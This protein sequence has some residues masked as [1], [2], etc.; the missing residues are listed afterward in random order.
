MLGAL[1][2]ASIEQL[3]DDIPVALRATALDLPRSRAGAGTGAPPERLGGAQPDG[4]GHLPGGRRLPP[5]VPAA[6]DQILLRGECYT[7]YTPYQPE[8]SQGTLQ[9]IYEYQSLHGRADR[10]GRRV[11]LALRRGC[12][13]RRGRLDELSRRPAASGCSSRARCIAHYLETLRTYFSGGLQLDEVPL[14]LRPT[15]PARP[16]SQRPGA[17]AGR[18][19]PAGRRRHRWASP[20]SSA[21]SSRWP[22]I[23][24]LAH[25]AGALFVAVIE[26]VSLAVL[27]P[28][29][30]YGADIA[31]GEGQ[32]LGIA[33]Q[34]G[35]PYLGILA[36]TDALVRQVP[37]RL[38]GHDH[39]P[40][41]PARVR[42]D[43][44]RPRAGHPARQG[45]QQHLH[46]PGAA[47]RSQQRSTSRRIGPH[48]LRDVAALGA[49]RAAELEAAL[50]AVGVPRI[51]S[52]AYLNE[53]AVR[54]PDARSAHAALL[55]R[56][57]LAGLL[58]ADWYP[59]DPDAGRRAAGV[60]DRGHHVAGDR[61]VRRGPRRD[62]GRTPADGRRGG[63]RSGP[64][65]RSRGAL[66]ER[67]RPGLQPTIFELVASGRGGGKV[68]HPPADALDR[69][70]ARRGG[71][72]A[73]PARA[74]RAGGRPPLRQP[75]AA[76]LRGGHRLLSARLVHHEV[77]PQDQRMGRAAARLRRR[78]TRSRPTRPR[79]ARSSCC[80]SSS[81]GWP[82][83][84]GCGR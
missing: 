42:H 1:G 81:R 64:E 68:P 67:D 31:A 52:G 65:P 11:R 8:I 72:A 83:S 77:Q 27:A 20:T 10:P 71:R 48:G 57:I 53:F 55:E 62:P 6:V 58:L 37:G 76:Q 17:N 21:C 61:A 41:R 78:S 23:G 3:F 43:A 19:R 45:R 75:L 70:P 40:R 63:S 49:A 2:I 46:E 33:P 69:I 56:G 47:A 39:R 16:I 30:E 22:A 79:R 66:D 25:A 84:A 7:A 74:E 54:V 51:H 15:R 35:G 14:A 60:R 32:P 50:A 73:R 24:E 28:P 12:G 29:G 38:V 4:P 59:A 82:R 80:G 36:A 13:H 34:Y 9:T 5:L 26:P 44:A 18:R